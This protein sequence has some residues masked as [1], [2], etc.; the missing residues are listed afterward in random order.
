MAEMK[1]GIL[2]MESLMKEAAALVATEVERVDKIQHAFDETVSRLKAEVREKEEMLRERS[3]AVEELETQLTGRIRELKN[4][5]AKKEEAPEG[6]DLELKESWVKSPDITLAGLEA[7]VQGQEGALREKEGALKE[8]QESFAA[9][10]RDLEEQIRKKE[11]LLQNRDAEI[12]DLRARL[13]GLHLSPEG[14]VTLGEENVVPP[15]ELE[16][17]LEPEFHAGKRVGTIAKG[18]AAGGGAMTGGKAI[19]QSMRGVVV[20]PGRTTNPERPAEKKSLLL[21]LL[22]PMKKRS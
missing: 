7:Q 13:D 6:R 4:Q 10:M 18:V 3:S 12:A 11:E 16:Q 8:L 15:E 22:G 19:G 9:R 14:S 20:R 1:Q 2:G 17:G 5:L 21:T